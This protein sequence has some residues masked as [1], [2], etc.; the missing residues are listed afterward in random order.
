MGDNYN[1]IST[2]SLF[3]FITTASVDIFQQLFAVPWTPFLYWF[4]KRTFENNWCRFLQNFSALTLLVGQQEG[5]L[6]C[7]N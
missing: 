2:K 7:K 5:H 6:A 4:Q 1:D 3:I